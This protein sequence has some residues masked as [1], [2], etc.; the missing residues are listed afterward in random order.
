[1]S[2]EDKPNDNPDQ[3]P[4][5]GLKVFDANILDD[6]EDRLSPEQ[7]STL[8]KKQLAPA[9]THKSQGDFDVVTEDSEV[10]NTVDTE[11]EDYMFNEGSDDGITDHN[12]E[13]SAA[14][15]VAGPA[16]TGEETKPKPQV[17]TTDAPI[18]EVVDE[19]DKKEVIDNVIEGDP[20]DTKTPVGFSEDINENPLTPL[21]PKKVRIPDNHNQKITIT[22]PMTV[23]SDVPAGEFALPMP[24][25]INADDP[26]MINDPT[27]EQREWDKGRVSGYEMKSTGNMYQP[28]LTVGDWKQQVDFNGVAGKIRRGIVKPDK[29]KR[30]PAADIALRIKSHLGTGG[31]IQIPLVNSGF[32][33]TISPPS[34]RTLNILFDSIVRDKETVGRDTFGASY[35]NSSVI[36]NK[37]FFSSILD[38]IIDWTIDIKK[39]SLSKY[40]KRADMSLLLWGFMA[41]LYPRG[42]YYTRSCTH[43]S[44][45][46]QSIK[47]GLLNI[48]NMLLIDDSKFDEDQRVHMSCIKSKG[49]SAK[50]VLNYQTKIDEA[51]DK[52]VIVKMD[53]GSESTF[54]FS[55][56]SLLSWFKDGEAWYDDMHQLVIKTLGAKA[57]AERRDAL[58]T[59]FAEAAELKLYTHMVKSVATPYGF[60]DGANSVRVALEALSSSGEMKEKFTAAADKYINDTARY[61]VG[62]ENYTCQTCG[63]PQQDEDKYLIPIDVTSSFFIIITTRLFI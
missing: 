56:G 27:A 8:M 37:R 1:M 57:D 35:T 53:D 25:R 26:A 12:D 18:P 51:D 24:G 13:V 34:Q 52:N 10:P 39:E 46:C 30:I 7:T 14:P 23:D 22:E 28:S 63:L 50:E 45:N 11:A 60:V 43:D 62:I 3:V 44:D 4:E 21:I 20:L 2:N 33:V 47:T 9:Q 16:V 48:H 15:V 17:D 40:I 29:D 42:H 6:I 54:G 61:V 55:N 5:E 31:V 36:T 41:A 19:L 32:Y 49:K 58:M 59:Q 38:A